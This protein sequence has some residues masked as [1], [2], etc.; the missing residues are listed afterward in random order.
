MRRV[1]VPMFLS[2][3]A[4]TA[5]AFFAGRESAKC[6]YA[7]T[8]QGEFVHLRHSS[9]VIL[10]PSTL[11][12]MFGDHTSGLS[13]YYG[14]NRIITDRGEPAMT[15]SP[16]FPMSRSV[17]ALYFSGDDWPDLLVPVYAVEK[18]QQILL[19]IDLQK[20]RIEVRERSDVSQK[21]RLESPDGGIVLQ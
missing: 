18:Q 9:I 6:R 19:Y 4:L 5:V 14:F 20:D 12:Q 8:A 7:V 16:L 13:L 17:R 11:S 1:I 21:R 10:S 3:A 15:R 2:V